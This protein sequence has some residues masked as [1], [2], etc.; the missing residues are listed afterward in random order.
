MAPLSDGRR[1]VGKDGSKMAGFGASHQPKKSSANLYTRLFCTIVAVTA[2]KILNQTVISVG[3]FFGPPNSSHTK[4]THKKGLSKSD[5]IGGGRVYP[6]VRGGRVYPNVGGLKLANSQ[7]MKRF[8]FYTLCRFRTRDHTIQ[9]VWGQDV[10]RF[11]KLG[12]FASTT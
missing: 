2:G 4:N 7:A 9:Y 8:I 11:L 6:N 1:L 12:N 5:N 10:D 3:P